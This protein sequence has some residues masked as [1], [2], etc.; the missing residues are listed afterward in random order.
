MP[1]GGSGEVALDWE[2]VPGATGYEV[3]RAA[4]AS[5]PFV[6]VV[7]VDVVDG[8]LTALA[9]VVNLYTDAHT[10][11]PDSGGLTAPD[12]SPTFHLVDVGTGERCYQVRAVDA[13]GPGAWSPTACG[14]PP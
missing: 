3:Q 9:D 14:S 1:G 13:S 11:I 6:V 7:E 2:A 12:A 8:D 10:Y 4:A 5:G